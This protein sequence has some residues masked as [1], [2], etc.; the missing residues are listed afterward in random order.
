MKS[1]SSPPRLKIPARIELSQRP[2]VTARTIVEPITTSMHRKLFRAVEE[3][4]GFLEPW[5]PWVPYNDSVEASL[6]YAEACESD[7]RTGSALR[8]SIRLRNKPNTIGVITLENISDLHRSC[9]LG[10]WLRPS[11]TGQGLMTEVGRML[12]E[13]AFAEMHFHRVRCAAGTE[14]HRSQGVIERLGFQREGIAREAERV[15]G[16]WVSHVVY[17]RLA[18]D[19][20]PESGET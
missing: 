15:F 19:A 12:L 7:W 8:F 13:F 3:S 11:H 10:Y 6:R 2:L 17:S 1:G 5:L 4:R 9:D 20:K 14:N 18:T 16:R